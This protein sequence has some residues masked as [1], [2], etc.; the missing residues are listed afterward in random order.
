MSSS[1]TSSHVR[2]TGS[3]KYKIRTSDRCHSIRLFKM[4]SMVPS[5][6][7]YISCSSVDL[8]KTRRKK[9]NRD[10]EIH[11]KNSLLVKNK[12][13]YEHQSDESYIVA[14]SLERIN[15]GIYLLKFKFRAL[16]LDLAI[17]TQGTSRLGSSFVSFSEVQG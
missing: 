4:I 15:G 3:T 16:K 9:L 12:R 10:L 6:K 7:I 1:L 17:T 5:R 2:F 11:E 8:K 14:T 13:C